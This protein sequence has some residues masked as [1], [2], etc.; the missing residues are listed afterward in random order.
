MIRVLFFARLRETLN[1]SQLEISAAVPTVGA[2]IEHLRQA[3]GAAFGD[4]L[5]APNVIVACN[6]D[7]VD[8]EHP[9]QAGDEVAFYPPVTGG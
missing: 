3:N 5:N 9:L 6:H 7:V 8:R 1:T 4:V 2:L